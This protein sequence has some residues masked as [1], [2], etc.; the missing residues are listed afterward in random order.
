DRR[1][2]EL[3]KRAYVEARYSASYEIGADDLRA[4]TNAV[5]KLRDTVEAVSRD[6]LEALRRKA[7]Q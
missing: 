4:I 3:A 2:F 6:W 5:R 7:H 1:R